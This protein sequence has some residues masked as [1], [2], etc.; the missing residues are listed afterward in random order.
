MPVLIAV[1]CQLWNIGKNWKLKESHKNKNN[2]KTGR[3]PISSQRNQLEVQWSLVFPPILCFQ[4]K[5]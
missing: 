5:L 2:Q 1:L 3:D 4:N